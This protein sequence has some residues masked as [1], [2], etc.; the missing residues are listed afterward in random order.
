M[1][2]LL[3]LS[4]TILA[5]GFLFAQCSVTPQAGTYI[6]SPLT[7]GANYTLN[8]TSTY[9]AGKAFYICNGTIVTLQ[10]RAGADTFYVATGAKLIGFEAAA[11]RVFVKSGATYDAMVSSTAIP[12]AEI[13]S[14]VVNYTGPP[15]PPC[16]PLNINMSIIG[17]NTCTTTTDVTEQSNWNNISLF[18]NP[19]QNEIAIN[20]NMSSATL[21]IVVY[22][23]IG[24]VALQHTTVSNQAK[25]DISF[26]AKGIY[27][28]RVMKGSEIVGTEK[29]VKN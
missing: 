14:T 2:K 4:L 5:S 13:G 3:L 25:L 20:I 6:M 21:N 9:P 22:D 18:P 11:F 1:K 17:P 19:A 8:G 28:L 15:Y 26:F 27:F 12:W 16:S 7:V 10:N 24:N 29:F 23:M